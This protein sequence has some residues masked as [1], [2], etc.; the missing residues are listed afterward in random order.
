MKPVPDEE[1]SS[2]EEESPYPYKDFKSDV[3]ALC[4]L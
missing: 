4:V 2:E 1:F 3:K